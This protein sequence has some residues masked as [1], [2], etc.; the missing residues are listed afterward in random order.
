MVRL[1]ERYIKEVLPTLQKE[2][3]RS[4]ILS[5]PRLEKIIVSMGLGKA[6]LEKKRFDQ[7]TKDLATITGQKPVLTRARKSVASF[8]VRRGMKV[9][10]MVTMRGA[11]MYEFLDRLINV[12]IPRIRDFRGLNPASFD[13]RGN[14]NFGVSEQLVFPEISVD[15][16]DIQLGMN[17]TIVV[18]NSDSPKESYRL[19]ELLGFPFRREG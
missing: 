1:Q 4:N 5:L 18:S 12:A 15:D 7:A 3:G 8:K 13:A 17:I 9:G 19:L 16:V 14:Y 10:A 11:R 2:V 6:I